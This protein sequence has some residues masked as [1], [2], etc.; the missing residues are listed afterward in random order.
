LKGFTFESFEDIQSNLTA[1]LKGLAMSTDMGMNVWCQ[2]AN[3]LKVT[4]LTHI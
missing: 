4:M 2:K 3:A 1:L